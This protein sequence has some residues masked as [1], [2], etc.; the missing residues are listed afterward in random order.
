MEDTT[1]TAVVIQLVPSIYLQI[2]PPGADGIPMGLQGG[3][4]PKTTD[5]V[6]LSLQTEPFTAVLYASVPSVSTSPSSAP[7]TSVPS[8]SS[9]S[10]T[11]SPDP[12]S[13]TP[14]SPTT[15]DTPDPSIGSGAIAGIAIGGVLVLIFIIG[16]WYLWR[17][18]KR[19]AQPPTTTLTDDEL[20]GREGDKM[21]LDTHHNASKT[22]ADQTQYQEMSGN[23]LT[24]ELDQSHTYKNAI[25]G[26][27][28]LT[29]EEQPGELPYAG[30]KER[31]PR[32]ESGE[33]GGDHG[34]DGGNAEMILVSGAHN[35]TAHVSPHVE[36]QRKREVE[37]L[38]M[39]E[40]RMRQR[41]EAIL[42]QGGG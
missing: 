39:E 41:R 26:A 30:L 36:A 31:G 27:H 9:S 18:K 10:P 13:S 25:G 24:Q 20:A 2:F 5:G 14:P 6:V 19:R 4:P 22:G 29:S 37:W 42:Q 15:T 11:G 3:E 32:N 38:E 7:N 1:L 28:E 16:G 8:P 17:R 33:V 23:G 35:P 40:T 34:D 12:V 21:V